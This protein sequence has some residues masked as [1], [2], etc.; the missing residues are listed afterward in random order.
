M[1]KDDIYMTPYEKSLQE[2]C[3]YKVNLFVNWLLHKGKDGVVPYKI[4]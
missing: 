4:R 1:S 3:N 2:L